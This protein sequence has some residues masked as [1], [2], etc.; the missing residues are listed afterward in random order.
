MHR[1]GGD[2]LTG[3]FLALNLNY[4]APSDI[5]YGLF[6]CA[7]TVIKRTLK[8]I[9]GFVW[10]PT[11]EPAYNIYELRFIYSH[12]VGNNLNKFM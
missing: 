7:R 2:E 11:T 12:T 4:F 6:K 3:L 8:T 9:F 5:R 1:G 10:S